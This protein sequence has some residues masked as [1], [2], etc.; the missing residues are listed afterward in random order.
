MTSRSV[1]EWVANHPDQAIPPRV[2]LRIWEREEG[3]CHLTR[4]KI[5]PGEAY[6]FEHVIALTCGGEHRERNIALALR[7]VHREK[8]AEDVALKSK[9]ARVR[10]KHIG[11][12]PKSQHPIR[13]RGFGP[14]RRVKSNGEVK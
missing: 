13:S 8:T 3:R 10:A 1:P 7:E 2:K 14:S 6:D 9:L 11:T 5:R 4:R 12:F